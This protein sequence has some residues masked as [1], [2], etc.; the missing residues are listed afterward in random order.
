M[1]V[2]V[3]TEAPSPT[4]DPLVAGRRRRLLLV[5]VAVV[6]ATV[7]VVAAAVGRPHGPGSSATL[8]HTLFGSVVPT[9]PS[10]P[11]DNS[12][13]LGIRFSVDG[14]GWITA[15][16]FYQGPQN[17]GPHEGRLWNAA[18]DELAR[19][20]FA[21]TGAAGWQ[22]ARLTT[23]VA[24][25]EGSTY[26]ASYRAPE[27]HYAADPQGL[28][29]PAPGPS[30][31]TAQ[32]SVY[33]YGS[34]VPTNSLPGMNYYV[35]VVFTT[36]PP[37]GGGTLPPALPAGATATTPAAAPTTGPSSGRRPGPTNTGVPVGTTLTPYTGPHTITTPGTTID[38]K[39]VRGGLV[40]EAKNVVIRDSKVHDDPAAPAGIY[41]TDTGS[42]TITDTEIYGFPVGITYGNW[43]AIRVNMHDLTYDGMKISSNVRLEDSWVHGAKPSA[44]AHWD[45]GQVQ[46]GVT[47]TVITGNYIDAS[48]RGTNSALFLT[49]DLGPSTKGPLTVTGNWLDGGNFTV[50]VLDGDNGKYF[51]SDI[52]VTD[53]RFGRASQY[54]PANVNVPVTWSG[55]TWDDTGKPINR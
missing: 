16:R 3:E 9:V 15:L 4:Q 11:D 10:A 14:P 37:P 42:A 45:G 28:G 8:S 35:D 24:V 27:G 7:V 20:S 31:L 1:D 48:S 21:T 40:I 29:A 18:G 44:D 54:G 25:R 53:N 47:N 12:V 19:V 50:C 34:G 30:A 6:V 2:P 39:D 5:A 36:A 41:V 43:T 49:P 26:T 22:E 33:T 38:A 32:Q 52:Q 55:N 17:A 23:P 13:E 51:I 46:D